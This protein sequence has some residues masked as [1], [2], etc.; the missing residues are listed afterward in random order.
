MPAEAPDHAFLQYLTCDLPQGYPLKTPMAKLLAPA[1][2]ISARR[3]L[4]QQQDRFLDLARQFLETQ[5]WIA[6]LAAIKHE[7]VFVIIP[8]HAAQLVDVVDISFFNDLQ[9]KFRE[10]LDVSRKA[11]EDATAQ[12]CERLLLLQ[13]EGEQIDDAKKYVSGAIRA[14]FK[15]V[16]P[17]PPPLPEPPSGSKSLRSLIALGIS[18]F[19]L[20]AM[21]PWR[22]GGIVWGVVAVIITAVV[23][24]RIVRKEMSA[25][26]AKSVEFKAYL[27][28]EN[29]HSFCR[30]SVGLVLAL[31]FEVRQTALVD[32]PSCLI[33]LEALGPEREALEARYIRPFVMA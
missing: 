8:T 33:A 22:Y 16:E 9:Q 6:Y 11:V 12:D 3:E 27:I 1:P 7:A 23:G 20:G 18:G 13:T 32:L 4:F 19:V 2:A 26:Q 25:S 5:P 14:G 21:V 10:L 17:L 30:K 15:A 28:H 31:P 29:Y 24:S